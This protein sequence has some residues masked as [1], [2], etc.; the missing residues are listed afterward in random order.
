MRTVSCPFPEGVTSTFSEEMVNK[1]DII[2]FSMLQK[3]KSPSDVKQ[4]YYFIYG[5]TYDTSGY[6]AQFP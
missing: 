5:L 3:S 2:C 1:R 4:V 6:S